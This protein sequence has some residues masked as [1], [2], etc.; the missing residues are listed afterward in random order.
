MGEI[1]VGIIGTGFMGECHALAFTAVVPLFQPELRPRLEMVADVNA[2]AAERARAPLR[3]RPCQRRLARAGGRPQGRAGL[4]HLAQH[5][6]QGDGAGGDRRRQ[7]RLLREAAGADGRGRQGADAGGRGRGRAH[8]GRL[9]LS[10]LAGDPAHQEAAGRRA[11]SGRSTYLRC[12]LRRR[13]HGRPRRAVLLA[14]RARQGR[15]RRPRRPGQP[16]H[17]RRPLPG[18]PD[19]RG[20]GRHRHGGARAG[21]GAAG[22]R[23]AVRPGGAAERAAQG[24]ER[25]HRPLPVPLRQRRPGQPDHQPRRLGPQE[26]PR[27]RA[28][29]HLGGGPLPPGALQRVRAVPRLG[30]QGRQW[31]PHRVL[32]PLPWRLRPVHARP[33]PRHRLQ[34]PQGDRGRRPARGH[35]HRRAARARTSARAGRSRRSATPSSKAPD[36]APGC[37]SKQPG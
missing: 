17:Q 20:A 25:G 14:L 19:R 37:G 5:P 30:A 13:L 35:R 21:G 34:R 3:L 4:D 7:A 26:R 27:P 18:R 31:L 24:G 9:Q 2:A 10:L 36:A 6:A 33:R 11:S 12:L 8:A 22:R 16:R 1:G 23:P 32:R 15:Q 29:R 28:L